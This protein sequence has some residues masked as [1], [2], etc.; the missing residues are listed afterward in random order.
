[1][2]VATLGFVPYCSVSPQVEKYRAKNF[3]QFLV[4]F[5]GV[6]VGVKLGEN[7]GNLLNAL[8]KVMYRVD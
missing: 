8:T 2:R 1:M 4:D 3:S 7:Q 6:E 5:L